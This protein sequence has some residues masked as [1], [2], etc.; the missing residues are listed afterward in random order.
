LRVA[1][2]GATGLIGSALR[3]A[4]EAD[5][6][7]VVAVVRP[8][9]STGGPSIGWDLERRSIDAQGLVGVD[10]VV[11]LAGESIGGRR[12]NAEHKRKVLESRT[13]S[14]ALLAETLA[15]LDGGPQVLV[16]GSAIG[17]YGDRGDDVLTESAPPQPGMFLSDVAVA[18]EAAARPAVDAGIRTC[19]T[20]TGIVLDRSA[21]ALPKLLRAFRL[22]VGGKLGTGRQWMSWITI[23]DEVAALRF[24]LDTPSAAGPFNLTAPEPATNAEFSTAVGEELGRPSA[25]P[26][27]QFAPKLLLGGEMAEQLLF[28][29]QRVQPAALQAA[30]FEFGFPRLDVALHHVLA[31]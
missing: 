26:V 22:F 6:D 8:G 28:A 29:S 24:L 17:Y 30:G 21:G 5:G 11:H 1:V 4:L 13:I 7:E 27:P 12:W 23:D 3:R 25:V 15:D 2:T 14:T 19:F 10:A 18:W 20:R 31:A 16:S 9:S